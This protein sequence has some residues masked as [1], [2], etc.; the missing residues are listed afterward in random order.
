M[1]KFKIFII[2]LFLGGI[3][4]L[5]LIYADGFMPISDGVRG[6]HENNEMEV[7]RNRVQ[8]QIERE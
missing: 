7:L 8:L 4:T 6:I 1:K 2:T 5:F 3:L